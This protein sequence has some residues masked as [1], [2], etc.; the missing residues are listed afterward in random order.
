MNQIEFHVAEAVAAYAIYPEVISLIELLSPTMTADRANQT[1]QQ[2][3]GIRNFFADREALDAFHKAVTMAAP[4]NNLPNIRQWGDFQTPP[5]LAQQVCTYLAANGIAPHV[6]IEPTYGA[7]SFILAALDVFPEVE[8]VYGV[9][10]Q[11]KYVWHLKMALLTRALRGQRSVAEIELHRDDIF[12]HHFADRVRRARD[13]LVIG[14]PPW[15][16]NAEL[17]SLGAKNLPVK[18]NI[19]TLNGMD[20]MTGKSNFDLGEYVLLQ[21]LELFSGQRG[22]LAMLCKNAVIKNIM[23]SL[24]QRQFKIANIRALGIDAGKAFGAAVEA[25]LL[26]MDLGATTTTATCQVATLDEPKHV[27]RVFGWTQGKFVSDFARYELTAGIDGRSSLIWRQGLKHDCSSIMELTDRNGALIN[28]NGDAVDI[29]GGYVYSL[30]KSSDLRDFAVRCAR[31]KVIVT[32][33]SLEED[34]S[35]LQQRA[36]KLWVYLMHNRESLD[37]RKSSIYRGKPPFSIFG[38]GEYAFL[39]YKV[40]ISGLYKEPCFSIALPIEGRP[41]ML[42]DTCYFLGFSSYEDALLTASLL[43]SPLVLQ[44]LKSVVFTDAKRPYTKEVLMRI[45][46]AQVA[47]QV[48]FRELE[49]LWRE[50]DYQPRIHITESDLV[51]Y[52]QR[53]ALLSQKPAG[54]QLRLDLC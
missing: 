53:L 9:E 10:I 15:V 33:R 41:V 4:H 50:K 30:L 48:A 17:G 25:S 18:R 3:T 52:R 47:T 22:T 7:G 54:A 36:P 11:E 24:P 19:K 32:Q 49:A 23:E 27:K 8:L 43:N 42:D 16:T 45:D 14:N 51:Q 44:F 35:E 37:R 6:I 40:A 2:L 31:K 12:T 39:P 29:E 46:L 28:G 34:M 20:A 1:L 21:M 13:V 38:I 5:K 26:F